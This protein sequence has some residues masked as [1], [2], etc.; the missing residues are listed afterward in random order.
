[1]EHDRPATL[2]LEMVKEVEEMKYTRHVP[3]RVAVHRDD[4]IIV[5]AINPNMETGP[6]IAGGAALA[7]YNGDHVGRSDIDIFS[8]N[9]GQFHD[10]HATIMKLGAHIVYQS[11]S[12]NTYGLNDE[13][14]TKI[15]TLQLICRRYF[16]TAQELLENFD[17]SVCKVVT[18]GDHFVLGDGTAL[19]INDKVLRMRTPLNQDA[20]KRLVKYW[21]YGYY[22]TDELLEE[23][24]TDTNLKWQF[25]GQDGEYD[26]AF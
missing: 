15:Y 22:P 24:R 17:I 4:R 20:V 16:D 11:E 12:A 9:V 1:M 3:S 18:D 23:V 2:Y 8:R 25:V 21:C 10:M 26:N 5:N 7:W 6:W 13:N 14:G 19:D